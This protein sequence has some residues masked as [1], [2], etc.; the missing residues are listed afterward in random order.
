MGFSHLTR[1]PSDRMMTVK[2]GAAVMTKTIDS[3]GRLVLG[4]HLAGR[5]V[6]IDDTDPDRIVITLAEPI[7]SRE[8][9]LY[10]NQEALDAVRTGLKQAAAR[11]FSDSPP[12]LDA[13]AALAEATN[14]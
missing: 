13:D 3:R 11:Q 10:K 6:I 12:D 4:N 5:L 9:W 8:A 14:G 7:P 1:F 2:G